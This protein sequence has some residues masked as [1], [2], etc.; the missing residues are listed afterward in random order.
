MPGSEEEQPWPPHW[1]EDDSFVLLPPSNAKYVVPTWYLIKCVIQDAS[2]FSS[3]P[4]AGLASPIPFSCG[5]TLLL[6]P[7]ASGTDKDP[8]DCCKMVMAARTVV[9]F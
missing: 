6:P 9:T 4:P 7:L 2:L 3:V 8:S 1:Q 5:C